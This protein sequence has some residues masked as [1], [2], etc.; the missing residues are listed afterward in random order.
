MRVTCLP[1]WCAGV[2][3]LCLCGCGGSEGSPAMALAS[4]RSLPALTEIRSFYWYSGNGDIT[5]VPPGHT[6]VVTDIQVTSGL[7]CEVGTTFAGQLSPK[8]LLTKDVPEFHSAVGIPFSQPSS[9]TNVLRIAA[10]SK[11]APVTDCAGILVGYL[12][13][14]P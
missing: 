4:T 14:G 8:I 2:L 13:K 11:A 6:L 10:Q 7:P 3:L 9:T 5:S 1:E 12:V